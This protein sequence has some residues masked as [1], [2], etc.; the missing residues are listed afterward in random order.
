M[1]NNKFTN[2]VYFTV[3]QFI[4]YKIHLGFFSR[5]LDSTLSFF[6][7]KSF[8][9][10]FFNLNFTILYLKVVLNIINQLIS[11]R[12]QILFSIKSSFKFFF[13]FFNSVNSISYISNS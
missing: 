4:K 3:S 5:F 2:I 6:L 10:Y 11:R 12:N 9:F 1:E 8:N 7:F 13:Q